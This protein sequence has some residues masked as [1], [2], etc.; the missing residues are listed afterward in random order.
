MSYQSIDINQAQQLIEEQN[1]T[2]IDVRDLQS[3]ESAHLENALLVNDET[4]EAFLK[5]TD[6]SEPLLVY[7]YHG[8]ISQ[9]AAEFFAGSGFTKVYSMDGG[10]EAWRQQF[11]VD[12]HE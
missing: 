5:T 1:V 2:V 9:N 12:S 10:F 8:H 6:K 7:C 3:Y 11:R 4:I